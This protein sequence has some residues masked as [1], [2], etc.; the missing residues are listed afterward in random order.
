MGGCGHPGNHSKKRK[1]RLPKDK[2]SSLIS[3]S[4]PRGSL[5]SHLSKDTWPSKMTST[6]KSPMF[7][8]VPAYR[9]QHCCKQQVFKWPRE[10]SPPNRSTN[11]EY[12]CQRLAEQI[13]LP[14][15]AGIG[16]RKKILDV[17][18]PWATTGI[19]ETIQ[20]KGRGIS[21]ND[22]ISSLIS[23]SVSR[24]NFLKTVPGAPG[25]LY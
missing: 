21:Q 24:G 3:H 15:H 18:L 13:G 2:I 20:K 10:L 4:V 14:A 5:I 12:R 9:S 6:L 8:P 11:D 19:R 16:L 22:K 7:L 17:V 23:H 1:G 25:K